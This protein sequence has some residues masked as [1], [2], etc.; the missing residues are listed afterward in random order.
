MDTKD[1]SR[2][3]ERL[4]EGHDYVAVN[5]AFWLNLQ[6]SFKVE[7]PEIMRYGTSQGDVE[8][9]PP[10]F[11]ISFTS[12][13]KVE[14]DTTTEVRLEFSKETTVASLLSSLEHRIG[15]TGLILKRE[16]YGD[17]TQVKFEDDVASKATISQ[18][19]WTSND[20]FIVILP[21]KPASPV[22]NGNRVTQ[23]SDAASAS[24]LAIVPVSSTA[25]VYPNQ[26]SAPLMN[27][28]DGLGSGRNGLCGLQNLG[29]TCYLNAVVQCLSHTAPLRALILSD[30]ATKSI[31]MESKFGRKGDA[32]KEVTSLFKRMWSGKHKSVAPYAFKTALDKWTPMFRGYQQ[33]DAHEA[34]AFLLDA[35][36][37]DTNLS[38][39]NEKPS[40]ID[41]IF[42]G[43]FQS[44]L[45]CPVCATESTSSESFQ[46]V[47]LEMLDNNASA[48]SGLST[49]NQDIANS[50]TFVPIQGKPQSIEVLR[51]SGETVSDLLS[52]VKASGAQGVDIVLAKVRKDQNNPPDYRSLEVLSGNSKLNIVDTNLW[53]IVAFELD[54]V[55]TAGAVFVRG[56]H[57]MSG[58]IIGTPFVIS[59][60]A[61]TSKRELVG[62][63]ERR[64]G[65]AQQRK[66]VLRTTA[67]SRK[68]TDAAIEFPADDGS[69]VPQFLYGVLVV[70]WACDAEDEFLQYALASPQRLVPPTLF[71]KDEVQRSDSLQDRI[72]AF[73]AAE[74]LGE[75]NL[76]HCPKC[77]EKRAASKQISFS[78]PLPEI[79][80]L[81]L[82]RFNSMGAKLSSNV[83]FSAV[84]Q[85]N[86]TQYE[87]YGIIRHHGSTISGGHYDALVRSSM[88]QRWYQYNDSDVTPIPEKRFGKLTLPGIEWNDPSACIFFYR[89]KRSIAAL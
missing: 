55:R 58:K 44:K 33:Q 63:V 85:V 52:K 87:L 24:S 76:W 53:E 20:R 1:P 43:S 40:V 72:Q 34:L 10:V 67:I 21:A 6:T 88:D 14:W 30:Q 28:G 19:G 84:L 77:E 75:D 70:D 51:A 86:Q 89:K 23:G 2:L 35:L 36:H 4:I 50:L 25:G 38:N 27:R 9:Y 60:N 3:R 73:C 65:T 41:S 8:V 12:F 68:I 83:S 82:K 64:F 74:V 48:S 15:Q 61:G 39:P 81:H 31:N 79:L 47:S 37:E 29:N 56:V 18:M 42:G 11:R 46:V 69:C 71:P 80:V 49:T 13:P 17:F 26:V 62:I 57:Q 32:V 22:N 78:N 54:E 16:S 45:V 66:F 59:I 5:E 7:G